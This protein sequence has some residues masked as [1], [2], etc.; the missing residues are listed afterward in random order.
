VAVAEAAEAVEA[1]EA[2]GLE[3]EAAD[4]E[5]EAAG[6]EAAGLAEEAVVQQVQLE[7]R[8]PAYFLNVQ[9]L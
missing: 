2:A 8:D 3:E 5:E 1:E 4:L 9:S 7:S 6:L